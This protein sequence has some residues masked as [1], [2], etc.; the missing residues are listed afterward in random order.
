[1]AARG[2]GQS[3]SC[4]PCTRESPSPPESKVHAQ[5]LGDGQGAS[6]QNSESAG[7]GV[8]SQLL[9]NPLQPSLLPTGLA[10]TP[11]PRP[12]SAVSAIFPGWLTGWKAT[13]ASF[14][15]MCTLCAEPHTR[16]LI[17]I[18]LEWGLGIG[19]PGARG[20]GAPQ[21]AEL[22][23]RSAPS[24]LGDPSPGPPGR[25]MSEISC[26]TRP[27]DSRWGH[28]QSQRPPEPGLGCIQGSWSPMY[29]SDHW[30]LPPNPLALLAGSGGEWDSS[31]PGAWTVTMDWAF[32]S[33]P[34]GV[35]VRTE[36][37]PRAGVGGEKAWMRSG[38]GAG[39]RGG[40]LR[41]A[42]CP[43]WERPAPEGAAVLNSGPP[44]PEVS[45]S[46]VSVSVTHQPRSEVDDLLLRNHQ[47]VSSLTLRPSAYVPHLTASHHAGIL[48][49]HI[50]TRRK[51]SRVQ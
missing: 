18:H 25:G 49:S 47:K 14:S 9:A 19:Q 32:L 24:G 35:A 39:S 42:A 11:W 16:A 48:S 2:Q 40:A 45:L 12:G 46:T 41:P 5:V 6:P 8:L 1:M 51:V 4:A 50:F 29:P 30:F 26:C 15:V 10:L 38:S 43:W 31:Q 27:S 17:R 7:P 21:G 22:T 34:A 20:R 33:P 44:L 3:A 13:A 37:T 36:G 28:P 23:K